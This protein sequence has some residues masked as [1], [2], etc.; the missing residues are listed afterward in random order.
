MDL[1][2][3]RHEELHDVGRAQCMREARV[4]GAWKREARQAEL[5]D[6]PEPLHLGRLEEALALARGLPLDREV[7]LLLGR[8]YLE[9]GRPLEGVAYLGDTPEEVVLKGRL[10]LA[11]GR[12]AEAASLLE[13]VRSRLSPESPLYRE[14]LEAGEE[15]AY[16]GLVR[17]FL[18]TVEPAR[19]KPFLE[20]ALR[21][22][23]GLARPLLAENLLNEG[24][25]GEAE[26]LGFSGPRLFL[27]QGRPA[28][29]LEL[30]M[31]FLFLIEVMVPLVIDRIQEK[32]LKIKIFLKFIN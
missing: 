14:A 10:L 16:L 7:R 12:L 21:R 19:A 28:E 9:L 29:A 20:E 32:S 23:P 5:T 8:L 27:R 15:R 13:E 3:T 24:R 22:F 6:A 11:G 25:A 4:L 2:K 31:V 17:L 18:D 26:A 1:A 30:L